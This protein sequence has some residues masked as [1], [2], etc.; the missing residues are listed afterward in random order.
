M[1]KHELLARLARDPIVIEQVAKLTYYR[2]ALHFARD[3]K[4][5]VL[6]G[7]TP[8]AGPLLVEDYGQ[9]Y[10]RVNGKTVKLTPRDVEVIVSRLRRIFVRGGEPRTSV[11][12]NRRRTSVA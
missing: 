1:T 10:A 9:V 7:L 8:G 3:A 2:I 11:V 12:W 5:A 6:I 4:N